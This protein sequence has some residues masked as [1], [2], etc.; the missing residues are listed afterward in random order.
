MGLAGCRESLLSLAGGAA[1][2]GAQ[3]RAESAIDAL[4]ARVT[5]PARDAK[6]DTARARIAHGALIPSRVWKDTSAWTHSSDKARALLI[7]GHFTDG[8]YRLEAARTVPLPARTADSRHFIQLTRLADGEYAWD[9]DVAYALGT[10]RARDVA[11]FVRLLLTA[12]E[13]RSE[14]QLRADYRS[15]IPRA[16]RVMGQLFR[17][18]SI[19]TAHLAD[20]STLSTLH[21]TITPRGIE[22]R[23][24][25]FA[26]Y[27]R[28]YAE[29]ARMHWRLAGPT[30]GVY[31]DFQMRD[32]RIRIR[33]R[34][35]D[36]HLVPVAGP[37]AA[38][39]DTL[40]L[41]G[42]FTLK[43]RI[44]TAGIREYRAAFI[45][46][47]TPN[48][49]SF[50]V[51]SREEPEWVLP[52]VTE[53]L[54]RSPLRRPFQGQGASFRM[55]VTDSAG[56]Q[57]LLLR[58]LHLEVQESAILRFLTRLSSAAYGDFAGKVEREQY[59]WLREVLA[60]LVLDLRAL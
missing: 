35:R 36:R 53:R 31:T 25:S 48:A 50:T 60:G 34:S 15:A 19:H 51:I 6:Y 13:G 4:A 11:A 5:D 49:T 16:A 21:A 7:G 44:F 28:K 58:Q 29:N 23:F 40:V 42:D 14:A 30:G 10:L 18:D 20:G 37:A 57:S 33:T 59:Q 8:R 27:M 9:T 32:G 38:M 17:M 45:L 41:L 12:G 52:L 43:V 46:G 39:P 47:N 54:L 22:D 2:Q 24:P 3:G 1:A 55:A 56:A 26:E